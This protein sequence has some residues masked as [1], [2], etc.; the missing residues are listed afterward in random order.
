MAFDVVFFILYGPAYLWSYYLGRFNEWGWCTNGDGSFNMQLLCG[1]FCAVTYKVAEI[2]WMSPWLA[3]QMWGIEKK[4]GLAEPSV[5]GFMLMRFA[6][7]IEFIIMVLPVV[8]LVVKVMEWTGNYLVLVFFLCT[9]LV[10]FLLSYLYPVVIS[11]LFSSYEDLPERASGMR[12]AIAEEAQEAGLNPNNVLL[13]RSF[14]Y[15]VHANAAAYQNRIVLGL[16]LFEVH[17]EKPAEI[18]AVLVHECGHYKK[19]HLLQ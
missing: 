2:V 9:A 15:D 3:Y 11:P 1:L 19:K 12:G 18:I 5:I 8:L 17:Q 7:I 16:P 10:K 14:D 4:Y 13:E 6:L